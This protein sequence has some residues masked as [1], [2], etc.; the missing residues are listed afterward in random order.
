MVSLKVGSPSRVTRKTHITT[1]YLQEKETVEVEKP[2]H[3]EGVVNV[4]A[5][6]SPVIETINPNVVKE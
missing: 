3:P 6:P 4:D 1:I 2:I 5:I